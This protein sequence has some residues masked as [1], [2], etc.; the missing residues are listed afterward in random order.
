MLHHRAPFFAALTAAAALGATLALS[1]PAQAYDV[2][3]VPCS[4]APL[5]CGIADVSFEK[6]DALPIEW[7]FDTGWIPQGSPLQVHL[8]AG[9]YANT[10]VDLAGALRT[11]WPQAFVLEA[12]GKLEGGA[13]GFHYG[14]EFHAQAMIDINVLGQHFTWVGDIPYVPQFDL[15]VK[16]D[17]VFNAWGYAPGVTIS[18]K[19]NPQTMISVSIGDIVGGSIPGIDGGLE[20][21]V[22]VELQATY[23]TDRVVIS[24]TDGVPVQGGPLT[25][26]ADTSNVLYTNGPNIELDIHPE[27]TVHYEGVLH[28][29]PAFY[30]ELLGQSWQ[31][32]IADIPIGFPITDTDWVFD[33]KRVHVPLPDL[34]LLDDDLDFGEVEVGQKRLLTYGLWNAGEAKVASTIASTDPSN[35]QAFDQIVDIDPGATFD[36]SVRFIPQAPGPF[37]ADLLITSNDPNAPVQKVHVKGVGIGVLAGGEEPPPPSTDIDLPSG[38]G[39]RTEPRS[40]GPFGLFAALAVAAIVT[41]RRRHRA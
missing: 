7:S 22:A 41:R 39:C 21:D 24:T 9:V 23:T 20:L 2:L 10:Y 28:L 6:V 35:F 8:W 3:A 27:G 25:S 12:P 32:P 15:Q 34:A 26:E 16:A 13:F 33:N 36:A 38:C 14:A 19:T 31:I 30:V 11:S 17:Q 29:I 5:T 40:E 1:S 37:E 4:D 18:G